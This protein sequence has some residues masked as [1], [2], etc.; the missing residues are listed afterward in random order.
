MKRGGREEGKGIGFCNLT[1]S[2][3]ARELSEERRVTSW[4]TP[5]IYLD[6]YESS[7]TQVVTGRQQRPPQPSR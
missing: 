2:G 6:V 7:T 3:V 1:I 5:S 4:M